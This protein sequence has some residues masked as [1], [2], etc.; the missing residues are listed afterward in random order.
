MES[1][2]QGGAA[3]S[4]PTANPE[5][6]VLRLGDPS[7]SASHLQPHHH[8]A[9]PPPLPNPQQQQQVF[10]RAPPTQ[11]FQYPPQALL[12]T[13]TP[14]MR[15]P[16]HMLQYPPQALLPTATLGMR[17]LPHPQA[18]SYFG[19]GESFFPG[20]GCVSTVGAYFHF[21]VNRPSFNVPAAPSPWAAPGQSILSTS[22]EEYRPNSHSTSAVLGALRN[23]TDRFPS[24]RAEMQMVQ[25]LVMSAE[26]SPHVVGLLAEG[27]ARVRKRVLA[28]IR[29]VVHKVMKDDVGGHA[30]F[31]EL[32][33]ACDGKHDELEFIIDTVCNGKGVLMKVF[34]NEHLGRK[35]LGELIEMMARNLPLCER[36]IRG[37]LEKECLLQESTG[38]VVLRHCFTVLPNKEE[39][40]LIIIKHALENI[41]DVLFS[42]F[43]WRCLAECL[44]N[45]HR[46]DDL[47]ALEEV[48]VKLTSEIAKGTWS[49]QLLQQILW[50]DNEDLKMRVVEGVARDIVD[51]AMH[52]AGCY[53]VEACFIGTTSSP[54]ALRRL[55]DALMPLGPRD[56][57]AL[58]L[59]CHSNDI[60]QKLLVEGKNAFPAETRALAFKI[61]GKLGAEARKQEQ[62]QTVLDL[63]FM[64]FP[65]GEGAP[66]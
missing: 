66:Q 23:G 9:I 40:S 8:A 31:L 20:A 38:D 47:K 1:Y 12:P 44:A 64:L 22:G 55:L 35:A 17:P 42:R 33:R 3:S 10:A 48:V 18:R 49:F 27:D 2:R 41:G 61:E 43:G 32:L 13:A 50:S 14:N 59:G 60:V 36:L 7:S 57:Q 30:V 4:N 46:G 63:I 5:A 29:H 39:C 54:E 28:G 37:L 53:V 6:F 25:D 24:T 62:A 56:L 51:L 19:D 34:N 45:A 65:F 21:G 11:M 52:K 58:V 16:P 26:G 15:P